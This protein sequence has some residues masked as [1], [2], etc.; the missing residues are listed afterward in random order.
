MQEV[1][2]EHIAYLLYFILNNK[3]KN[4]MTKP[5]SVIPFPLVYVLLPRQY[6]Q[7][8]GVNRAVRGDAYHVGAARQLL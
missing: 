4:G 7:L 2:T 1:P 3:H 6:L 5:A 8:S